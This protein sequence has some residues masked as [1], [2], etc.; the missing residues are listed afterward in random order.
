[1]VK[2]F[3]IYIFQ[4]YCFSP[5]VPL[6][7]TYIIVVSIHWDV[8]LIQFKM[9]IFIALY[10]KARVFLLKYG[11]MY[12]SLV[13]VNVLIMY[14]NYLGNIWICRSI[15]ININYSDISDTVQTTSTSP[16]TLQSSCLR[17]LC[18]C[19]FPVH[20]EIEQEVIALIKILR[21][22]ISCVFSIYEQ[23]LSILEIKLQFYKDLNII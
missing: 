20:Q 7:F 15:L 3:R 18:N 23:R 22:I 21:F 9:H 13:M 17:M 16:S 1:M 14:L 19:C 6:I 2:L 12:I 5:S 4:I 8:C 11:Y 10:K